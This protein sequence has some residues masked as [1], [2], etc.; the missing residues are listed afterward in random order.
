MRAAPL[1]LAAIALAGCGGTATGNTAGVDNAAVEN[2]TAPAAETKGW[3]ELFAMPANDALAIFE[4]LSFRP[5]AYEEMGGMM[6]SHGAPISLAD[7]ATGKKNVLT[8]NAS[9]DARQLSGVSFDVVIED[10]AQGEA[11]RKRA[12][13]SLSTALRVAGLDGEAVV[14]AALAKDATPTTGKV[15]GANYAVLRKD[16]RTTINFTKQTN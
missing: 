1:L 8:F 2:A 9:G 5:G 10:E 12:I 3:A 4:K 13:D 15:A 14:K 6:M 11:S 16:A 7:T